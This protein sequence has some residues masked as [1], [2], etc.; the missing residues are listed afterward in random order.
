MTNKNIRDRGVELARKVA[1]GLAATAKQR[2]DTS[3]STGLAAKVARLTARVVELEAEVQENRQL[4][5]RLAELTDVVQELLLPVA[6]RD[7]KRLDEI[8]TRYAQAL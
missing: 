4:N 3:D 6:Q 2:R 1:P 8:L 5:M 7:Q